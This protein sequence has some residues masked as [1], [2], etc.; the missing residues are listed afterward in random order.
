MLELVDGGKVGLDC[1][2][3]TASIILLD[4]EARKLGRYDL[5]TVAL[6]YFEVDHPRVYR[7]VREKLNH[8]GRKIYEPPT[9]PEARESWFKSLFSR[10]EKDSN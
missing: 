4:E 1:C 3:A 6:E 2:L 10:F 5:I 7:A 9:Q 8:M